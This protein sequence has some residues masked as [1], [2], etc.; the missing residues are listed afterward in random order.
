M[1]EKIDRLIKVEERSIQLLKEKKAPYG[2]IQHHEFII[3]HLKAIKFFKKNFG[4]NFIVDNSLG[5]SYVVMLSTGTQAIR[6]FADNKEEFVL[7]EETF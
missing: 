1:R 2:A 7:L 5:T 4:F 3:A 6:I